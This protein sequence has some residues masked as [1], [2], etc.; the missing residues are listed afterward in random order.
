MSL[1]LR[2]WRDWMGHQWP[3]LVAAILFMVLFAATSAVVPHLVGQIVDMFKQGS[4]ASFWMAPVIVGVQTVRGV[5][6][7]LQTVIMNTVSLR[8]IRN[9]QQAMF[10]HL[11]GSDLQRLTRDPPGTLVSRFTNDVHELRAGLTKAAVALIRDVLTLIGLLGLMFTKDWV[12]TLIILLLYPLVGIP[13]QRI[14]RKLRNVTRQTQEQMGEVTSFLSET[15]SNPRTIKTYRLETREAER[16]EQ[17]FLKRYKLLVKIVRRQAMV[18]SMLE[19]VGGLAV[20][21]VVVVA[22][23]R[24]AQETTTTGDFAALLIALLMTSQ[25]IRSLGQLHVSLQK[26][27]AALQ[28]LFDVL[29]ETNAIHEKPGAG[30][31]EVSKGCVRFEDVTFG[32]Q[33]DAVA[34][35][36]VS[37]TARGGELVALVGPSGAGKTTVFN[38][39]PRLYDVD[40]GAITIDG[41]DIRDVTIASLRD[42]IALVSQETALFN[43]TIRE[44][45]RFGR[46][47]ASDEQIEAA[48]AAADADDFIRECHQGYDTVV[49]DRGTRLSGGQRQR[50]AI[51]RAILRDAPILLLDEATSALDSEAERRV[52]AAL[53]RLR[54]G[55]TTF[56][57]AHRLSTVTEADRIVVLEGG[58]IIETGT[59]DEL[60]AQNGTYARLCRLQFGEAGN[61]G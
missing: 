39:I 9:F 11:T 16:S 15:F 54:Q 1:L 12:L 60:A 20:A 36:R 21:G 17:T 58:R 43:D 35:E 34:L 37:L 47:D 50:I 5:S 6:M 61:E 38:L 28:R 59:H 13:I 19:I 8:V 3:L 33:P 22:N 44:N 31:L 51:A 56:A 45:I 41:Q 27:G 53:D 10:I 24:I 2:L 32:Y 18:P 4:M 57:I 40:E 23:I 55:R 25:P 26:V 42:H 30:T 14:G 7:Y 29:D 46:L 52:Q 49:G 48:A